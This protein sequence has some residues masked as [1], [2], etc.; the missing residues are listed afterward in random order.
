MS[1]KKL[2]KMTSQIEKIRKQLVSQQYE[3]V[4]SIHFANNVMTKTLY[5]VFIQA[6]DVANLELTEFKSKKIILLKNWVEAIYDS[7]FDFNKFPTFYNFYINNFYRDDGLR[8]NNSDSNLLVLEKALTRGSDF[9]KIIQEYELGLMRREWWSDQDNILFS[10]LQR[11]RKVVEYFEP[12]I[13]NFELRMETALS[14]DNEFIVEKCNQVSKDCIELIKAEIA[15]IKLF[16]G[17]FEKIP[18]LENLIDYISAL[19][20]NDN[21]Y[22]YL[23]KDMHNNEVSIESLHVPIKL[24]DQEKFIYCSKLGIIEFLKEKLK[25]TGVKLTDSKLYPLISMITGN[26]IAS[27]QKLMSFH[28]NPE[29]SSE[30]NP[31]KDPKI[32]DR[33]NRFL[34]NNNLIKKG[35]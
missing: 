16:K 1:F 17:D 21:N 7:E 6:F 14:G 29:N 12:Y 3:D 24:Q 11:K 18:M 13:L 33:V 34:I 23:F 15:K 4:Y 32:M 26:N 10:E 35:D 28:N 22:D 27:V 2:S 31:F 8:N 25:D 5:N 30:G 19:G 9:I 20:I